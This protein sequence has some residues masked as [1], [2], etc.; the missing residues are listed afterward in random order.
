MA[1]VKNIKEKAEQFANK[2][3]SQKIIDKNE[4]FRLANLALIYLQKYSNITE[5]NYSEYSISVDILESI[6]PEATDTSR[7]FYLSNGEEE[8]FLFYAKFKIYFNHGTGFYVKIQY[9]H[10]NI[11]G[12]CE[13]FIDKPKEFNL[14]LKNVKEAISRTVKSTIGVKNPDYDKEDMNRFFASKYLNYDEIRAKEEE[15]LTELGYFQFNS[16]DFQTK[17]TT[18]PISW[19]KILLHISIPFFDRGFDDGGDIC[20]NVGGFDFFIE[21]QL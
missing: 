8:P 12:D 4:A 1:K 10:R 2:M 14:L 3:F 18:I 20:T 19:G 21:K 7:Y 17:I 11:E 6:Y 16:L 9:T 15:I 5:K 13:Y